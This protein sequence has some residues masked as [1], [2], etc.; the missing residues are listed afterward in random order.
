MEEGDIADAFHA[1]LREDEGMKVLGGGRI[2]IDFESETI[3]VNT[4]I[5]SFGPSDPTLVERTLRNSYEEFK[6]HLN[7]I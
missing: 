3:S 1:S 6:V 7:Q 5:S 2:E 4:T